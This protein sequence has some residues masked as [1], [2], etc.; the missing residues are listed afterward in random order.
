M[1]FLS[2]SVMLA[3]FAFAGNNDLSHRPK[4]FSTRTGKAVFADFTDVTYTINYNVTARTA[5]ARAEMTVAV[6][7]EGHIVFDSVQDP[8]SIKLD[9][10][11]VSATLQKTPGNETTVRVL[12]TAAQ[13]MFTFKIMFVMKHFR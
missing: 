3:S 10:S 6:V 9:G 2:L 1:K 12:D 11:P 7:E 4:S 5:A 8:T 13:V